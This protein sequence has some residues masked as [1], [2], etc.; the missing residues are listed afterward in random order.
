MIIRQ[1]DLGEDVTDGLSTH[2]DRKASAPYCSSASRSSTSVEELAALH[3]RGAWIDDH[4]VFIIDHALQRAGGHVEHEADAAWHALVEPNVGHRHGELDVAHTLTTH[5][6]EVTSTPQR[7]QTTPLC[8][9][10][11]YFPQ[12]HSQSR[13]GPK[14]TLAEQAAFFGLERAVVDGFRIFHFAGAPGADAVCE[15][16]QIDT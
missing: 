6:G 9:M 4:V 15:A 2:A 3:W 13:V 16:M 7:S 10:R 8:L 14:D 1:I 5:A 12:A 11:L